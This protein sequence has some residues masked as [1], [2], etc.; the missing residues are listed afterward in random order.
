ML[1]SADLLSKCL[2]CGAPL[3]PDDD[4]CRACGADPVVEREIYAQLT[5]AIRSQRTIFLVVLVLN[6]LLAWLVYDQLER[7]GG[8]AMTVVWP[9]LAVCGVFG[10]LWLA[11]PRAPLVCALVGIALFGSS[12]LLEIRRDGWWAL[13]PGAGLAL[14]VFLMI[15]F[16]FSV[17]A[18]L[19]ARRLRAR[20]VPRAMVVAS[21]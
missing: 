4:T 9:Q 5:P 17:R 21:M 2:R 16:G 3:A 10:V 8:D 19:T 11:V 7:H 6:A 20:R 18:G 15:A 12:W 13:T 1:P 14:H